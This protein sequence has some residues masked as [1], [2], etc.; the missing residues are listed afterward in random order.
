MKNIMYL[1]GKNDFLRVKIGV[2]DKPSPDYD[3]ANWVLSDF[4]K[5]DKIKLNK[6]IDDTFEAVKLMVAGKIEDSM[7]KYN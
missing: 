4:S 7:N 2:G 5:E 1:S 3:L 6:S